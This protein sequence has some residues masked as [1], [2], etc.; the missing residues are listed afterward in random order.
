M[1]TSTD[2]STATSG[3][4][5]DHAPYLV[6][7]VPMNGSNGGTTF[8]DY[9]HTVKG[10]GSAKT[11]SVNGNTQTSFKVFTME[12][13]PLFDGTGDNLTIP[14]SG[15]FDFGRCTVSKCGS[16]QWAPDAQVVVL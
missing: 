10:S 8:T 6:L 14:P 2:G 1:N 9:H 11:V 13:L 3:T 15:D 5:T 4:K 12:V 16:K 7:A